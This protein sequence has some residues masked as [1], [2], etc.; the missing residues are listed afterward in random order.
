MFIVDNRL[1]GTIPESLY[2]LSSLRILQFG[3]NQ[4]VGTISADISRLVNIEEMGLYYSVLP[5]RP[6]NPLFRFLT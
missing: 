4:L 1:S 6:L 3:G 5:M 2:D